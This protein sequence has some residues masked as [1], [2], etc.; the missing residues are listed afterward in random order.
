[1]KHID[2]SLFSEKQT[3]TDIRDY[4]ENYTL[5]DL[6]LVTRKMGSDGMKMKTSFLKYCENIWRRALSI[7]LNKQRA[8]E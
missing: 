3:R 6:I 7:F 2:R 5:R 1:M 4:S 8:T